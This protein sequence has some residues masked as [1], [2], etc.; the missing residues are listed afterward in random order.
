MQQSMKDLGGSLHQLTSMSCN[1]NITL[2]VLTLVQQETIEL[3][4]RNMLLFKKDKVVSIYLVNSEITLTLTDITWYWVEPFMNNIQ[5]MASL[6][7]KFVTRFNR[8]GQTMREQ[9]SYSHDMK[10]YHTKHNV[11]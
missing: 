8:W 4:W 9:C 5:D 11:E 1:Y 3:N 2:I 7:E 6:K 10:F